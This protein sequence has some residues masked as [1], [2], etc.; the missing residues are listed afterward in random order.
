MFF[1]NNSDALADGSRVFS[2]SVVDANGV[3]S[4]PSTLTVTVN[5]TDD[6]PTVTV[7]DQSPAF[8]ESQ[9]AH[10]SANAEVINDSIVLAD[11]DTAALKSATV[12]ITSAQAGDV[13]ALDTNT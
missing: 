9:G 10:N 1:F 13:L 5:A 6:T 2:V 8:V 3:E 4:D 12:E 7:T 11:L